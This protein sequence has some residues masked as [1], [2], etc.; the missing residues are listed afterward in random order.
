[1]V[2]VGIDVSQ[3]W[4][5]VHLH[6]RHQDLRVPNTPAGWQELADRLAQHP[7]AKLADD[8]YEK[9]VLRHLAASGLVVHCRDAAMGT[10]FC[11]AVD[12]GRF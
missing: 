5:D 3:D 8:G 4:L 11:S 9:G 10:Q 7:N 1:M 12:I 6:P 2:F